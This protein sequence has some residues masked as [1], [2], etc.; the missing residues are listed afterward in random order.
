MKN[1]NPI[2]KAGCKEIVSILM[3]ESCMSIGQI[4]IDGRSKA[5]MIH[6][7]IIG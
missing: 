1:Q 6:S 2:P 3:H 7:V 4:E 5:L